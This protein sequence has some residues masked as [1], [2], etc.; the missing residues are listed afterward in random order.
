MQVQPLASQVGFSQSL[1]E[2]WRSAQDMKLSSFPSAS[3]SAR[4]VPLSTRKLHRSAGHHEREHAAFDRA[5]ATSPSRPH[6]SSI[7]DVCQAGLLG[8]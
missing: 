6:G 7:A 4:Y 5:S 8:S 3:Q 2:L 1:N